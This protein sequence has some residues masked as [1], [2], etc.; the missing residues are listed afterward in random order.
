VRRSSSERLI[1][2]VSPRIEAK[3]DEQLRETWIYLSVDEARDLLAT[4]L[5]WEE[6]GVTDPGG[7]CTSERRRTPR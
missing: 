2:A 1:K 6:E 4:L 7:T 5:E 3:P